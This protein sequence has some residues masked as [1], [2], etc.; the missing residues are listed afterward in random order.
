[1]KKLAMVAILGAGGAAWAMKLPPKGQGAASEPT[2][3]SCKTAADCKG[4]LSHLCKQ[5]PPGQHGGCNH[6]AC[7]ANQCVRKSCEPD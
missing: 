6:W 1:M 3:Q 7:E 5:C 2:E 4:I